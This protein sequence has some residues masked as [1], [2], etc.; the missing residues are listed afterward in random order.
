M[1]N[2][3]SSGTGSAFLINAFVGYLMQGTVFVHSEEGD[4]SKFLP[5]SVKNRVFCLRHTSND[6]SGLM[7]LDVL[8]DCFK[9]AEILNKYWIACGFAGYSLLCTFKTIKSVL[10]MSATL[11]PA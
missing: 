9:G 11:R 8:N 2:P 6:I 1:R 3:L 4:M 7:I 5:D 10:E